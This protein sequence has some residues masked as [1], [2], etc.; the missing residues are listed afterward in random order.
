[1]KNPFCTS[2]FPSSIIIFPF[3]VL[4]FVFCRAREHAQHD[5]NNEFVLCLLLI[6]VGIGDDE[7]VHVI[8]RKKSL[9]VEFDVMVK[10]KMIL[11]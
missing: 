3:S 1:L 11:M 5:D 9:C 6:I 10:T 8:E 7:R 2:D 4:I